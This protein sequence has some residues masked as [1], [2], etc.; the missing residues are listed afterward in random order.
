M[1]ICERRYYL[2]YTITCV[3][4]LYLSSVVM[5]YEFMDHA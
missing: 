1:Y 3:C 4:T 5:L 2:L